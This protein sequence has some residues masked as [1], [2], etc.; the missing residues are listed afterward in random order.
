GQSGDDMLWIDD[1]YCFIGNNVGRRDH[2]PFVPVDPNRPGGFALVLDHEAF[3]VEDDI[4]HI[5]DHAGDGADFVLHS[6]DL[7]ALHGAAFKAGQENSAKAIANGDAKASLK[8]LGRKFAVGVGEG[9]PIGD[10]SVGQFQT[11]PSDTH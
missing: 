4:S 10:Q 2:A 5:L 1:L 6:L 11:S 3:D 8:R 7:E 9:V